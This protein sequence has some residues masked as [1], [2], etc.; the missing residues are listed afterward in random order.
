[1]ATAINIISTIHN[2]NATG[3]ITPTSS[4]L[5]TA[6]VNTGT[7]VGLYQLINQMISDLSSLKSTIKAREKVLIS[8]LATETTT[9]STADHT[10]IANLESVNNQTRGKTGALLIDALARSNDQQLAG[11]IIF[12]LTATI[13]FVNFVTDIILAI[14]D[15]RIRKGVMGGG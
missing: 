1:M 15:P 9:T 7:P 4:L 2:L 8:A 10:P 14:M 5:N 6:I 12:L 11:A 3:T 13:V